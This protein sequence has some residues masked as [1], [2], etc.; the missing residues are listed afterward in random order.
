M[1][2]PH[3]IFKGIKY[4]KVGCRKCTNADH[5]DIFSDSVTFIAR[6]RCGHEIDLS[7]DKIKDQPDKEHIV[8]IIK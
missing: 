2:Q 4:F 3:I 8:D 5:W 7:N 1:E 6:C